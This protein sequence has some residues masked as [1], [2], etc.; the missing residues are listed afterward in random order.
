MVTRRTNPHESSQ[1]LLRIP[2]TGFS[3]LL[4]YFR[5]SS[6]SSEHGSAGIA[7]ALV[8]ES[9][10]G[11]LGHFVGRPED[12]CE[13]CAPCAC[14]SSDCIVGC[15]SARYGLLDERLH[16]RRDSLPHSTGLH[17]GRG[18]GEWHRA[19]VPSA[20]VRVEMI[21]PRAFGVL[22]EPGRARGRV[23]RVRLRIVAVARHAGQCVDAAI[24][25]LRSLGASLVAAEPR[26]RTTPRAPK[27]SSG[28]S[29][30][31]ACRRPASRVRQNFPLG[32]FHSLRGAMV[33]I[34]SQC[35]TSFPFSKRKRS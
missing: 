17:G 3:H 26:R 18:L 31:G 30:H 14:S 21:A 1:S 11:A 27:R 35:S 15:Q 16:R 10:K 29:C 13:R 4:R 24:T 19:L 6:D 8:T 33:S 23:A 5:R 28:S 34:V 2:K 7:R 12:G 25:A 9:L 32:F 20:D 22:V